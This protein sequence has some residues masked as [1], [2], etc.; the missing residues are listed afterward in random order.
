MFSYFGRKVALGKYYPAPKFDLVIEPFA[1]SMAYSLMHQ[2]RDGAIG[3]EANPKV[4]DTWN[5]ICGLTK[6]Q[7]ENYPIPEVGEDTE[8]HWLIQAAFSEH[9]SEASKRRWTAR[10]NRDTLP[11]IRYALKHLE[12]ARNNVEY[13]LGHYSDAP[14]VEATWFIDPPYQHVQ[15]GY[16]RHDLD[17]GELAEFCMSRR[18]QVIVCEQKGADWLPFEDLVEIRGTVNK[19]TTE[20]IW[21]NA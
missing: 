15:K 11:Q 20:V 8:D 2:T 19:R 9:A 1:G 4:V 14:D 5:R 17:Y 6:E 21:V 16:M 12:Y 13:R 18:G 10:M 7:I 3:I